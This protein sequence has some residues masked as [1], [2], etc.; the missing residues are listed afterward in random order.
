M[1][2]IAVAGAIVAALGAAT[3]YRTQQEAHKR[4]QRLIQENLMHQQ[5]Y[6]RQAEQAALSRA[7]EFAPL[8]RQQKQQQ[9]EQGV[10]QRMVEPVARAVPSMQEQAAVQGNVSQDYAVGRATSQAEQMRNASA[11]ASIL[12]K[13]MGA[14]R[15][16]QHEALGMAE[17]G[18]IIDQLKSFS[19]GSNSAAQIGIQQAGAPDGGSMIGGALMQ[20]LGS[21]GMMK[22]LGGAANGGGAWLGSGITPGAGGVKGIGIGSGGLGL[23]PGGNTLG[24]GKWF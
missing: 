12:G 3:Q 5:D 2:Y 9:I 6:Q 19:Q 15:L 10:A 21:L 24:F 11:L 8:T 7:Q 23:K 20:S 13:T 14:G 16:R 1:S 4:Q 18:Q 17:T 22:G